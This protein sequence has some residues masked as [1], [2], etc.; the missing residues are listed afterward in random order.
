MDL[1]VK[2][3]RL[4]RKYLLREIIAKKDEDLSWQ[5]ALVKSSYGRLSA[6]DVRDYY[7]KVKNDIFNDI[8]GQN[9]IL[10]Q[11]GNKIDI[12]TI[13]KN[14]D[15][16]GDPEDI[17]HWINNKIIGI[18]SIIDD[19]P[20]YFWVELKPGKD[21]QFEKTKKIVPEVVDL[22]KSIPTTKK[23]DTYFSGD[24]GFIIVGRLFKGQPINVLRELLKEKTEDYCEDKT[25]VVTKSKTEDQLLIDISGL[26]NTGSIPIPYS[27]NEKTGLVVVPVIDID[28]F[29]KDDAVIKKALKNRIK[30]LSSSLSIKQDSKL[31]RTLSKAAQTP[32]YGERIVKK[33]EETLRVRVAMLSMAS[34]TDY[35]RIIRKKDNDFYMDLIDDAKD[36]KNRADFDRFTARYD[37]EDI[38]GAYAMA[39]AIG[40]DKGIFSG[41]AFNIT[42]EDKEAMLQK[43]LFHPERRYG[44]RK[45]LE[46][47]EGKGGASLH[48]WLMKHASGFEGSYMLSALLNDDEWYPAELREK[49]KAL[50]EYED[51]LDDLSE[52]EKERI[53]S[54]QRGKRVERLTDSEIWT[55]DDVEETARDIRLSI[56]DLKAGVKKWGANPITGTTDQALELLYY[57]LTPVIGGPAAE[58][59]EDYHKDIISEQDL[60]KARGVRLPS[61]TCLDCGQK[62]I[63]YNQE[64]SLE[65]NL[66][67]LKKEGCHK[68]TAIEHQPDWSDGK[69][70][71]DRATEPGYQYR[72][73]IERDGTGSNSGTTAIEIDKKE[74]LVTAA[75]DFRFRVPLD[76]DKGEESEKPKWRELAKEKMESIK[77]LE[78]LSKDSYEYKRRSGLNFKSELP[79]EDNPEILQSKNDFNKLVFNFVEQLKTSPQTK[80]AF[81]ELTEK[82]PT[83]LNEDIDYSISRQVKERE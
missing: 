67:E 26:K 18:Q 34:A 12:V 68:K 30:S 28:S 3:A 59:F 49:E 24:D 21:F 78:E 9:V 57:V 56:E 27:L 11:K 22:V 45:A 69:Y 19:N 1:K 52:E 42:N 83:L 72:L 2:R 77:K 64:K 47:F 37:L 15:D 80:E 71:K 58:F 51:V 81:E 32:I 66:T 36:V 35:A 23:V 76:K 38:A 46:N 70:D 75:A 5:T 6:Q 65:E 73:D 31:F 63:L 53:R 8:K 62:Y 79:S 7:G 29:K 48:T 43:V 20:K 55:A 33:A 60:M 50:K 10:L 82:M 54:Q 13:N 74:G 4:D 25:N 41:G 61:V 16:I 17:G 40:I 39:A 44:L 14:K